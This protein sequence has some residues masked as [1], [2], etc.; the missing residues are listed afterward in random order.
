MKVS[1][2]RISIFEECIVHYLYK[3]Y[4]NRLLGYFKIEEEYF[5]DSEIGKIVH[6]E[7]SNFLKEV[8]K[9]N[10]VDTDK[11][12]K[13]KN[14]KKVFISLQNF[15]TFFEFTSDSILSNAIS[16]E[17]EYNVN[18]K[19]NV[20]IS[21]KPDLLLHQKNGSIIIYDWKT[22]RSIKSKDIIQMNIYA[23]FLQR[24]FNPKNLGA[25]I[26]Q[27][28][29]ILNVIPVPISFINEESIMKNFNMHIEQI[30]EYDYFIKNSM[31]F[32]FIREFK[33]FLV[34]SF[35]KNKCNKCLYKKSC[36]INLKIGGI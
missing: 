14:Y 27:L 2:S 23:Y 5:E 30:L 26:V 31:D 20:E 10:F 18:F 11:F 3:Y 12:L 35:G 25:Y 34:K 36:E 21:I 8:S 28:Y 16:I 9:T 24:I 22:G 17:K 33:K 6:F 1:F 32:E 4:K 29:P 13:Y 7:I 15:L 19:N